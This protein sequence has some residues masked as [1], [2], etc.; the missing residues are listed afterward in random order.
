MDINVKQLGHNKYALDVRVRKDGTRLR[1]RETVYGSYLQATERYFEIRSQLKNATVKSKR[2]L[3]ASNKSQ[4]TTLAKLIEIY[5]LHK[6]DPKDWCKFIHHNLLEELGELNSKEF[7]LKL[8]IYFQNL[9]STISPNTGKRLSNGT[10]NRYYSYLS[11]VFNY[12]VLLD[13]LSKNPMR[14]I[15]KLKENPRDRV[16]TKDE[17]KRF[18]K[19]LSENKRFRFIEPAV[20]FALQIPIRKNELVNLTKDCLDLESRT[21]RLKNGTT[22]NN[23]GTYIP[24][25]PNMLSHFKNIPEESEY[26]FYRYWDGKYHSLGDFKKLWQASLSLAKIDDFRFHDTRHIAA[27]ALINNGTPERVVMSIA[28]WKSNMLS[29]YYHIN[30]HANLDKVKFGGY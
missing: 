24:I 25:P 9:Q 26:L 23:R 8:P 20:K 1:K 14:L 27:S 11:S 21:I 17:T 10:I 2:S 5:H 3:T 16:L 13:L 4:Q 29:T 19:V 15:Q 18:L 7:D 28:N 12:S 6:G 22:K 30:S